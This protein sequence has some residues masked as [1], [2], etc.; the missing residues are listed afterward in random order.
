[1]SGELTADCSSPIWQAPPQLLRAIV[2]VGS[3]FFPYR[4]WFNTKAVLEA[5]SHLCGQ[6]PD[7]SQA[8]NN[9][10]AV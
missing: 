10:W 2:K 3:R 1:M 7:L 9:G 5:E 8:R 6:V 4:I